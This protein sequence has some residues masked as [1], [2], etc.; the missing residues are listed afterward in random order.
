M[1]CLDSWLTCRTGSYS[2][3]NS[4]APLS[5]PRVPG[6]VQLINTFEK[7]T[8]ASKATEEARRQKRLKRKNIAKD[9]PAATPA[10]EAIPD[11][12][13]ATPDT[14]KKATKKERKIAETK[15]SEQQQHKSANEAARMAVAGLFG[16]RLGGKKSGRT[17][18]WMKG[19]GSPAVTPGKPPPSNPTSTVGTPNPE[20][21]RPA[22][23]KDKRFGLWDEDKDFSIQARDV[24][25]V[26][27]SDGR[28]SRGFVRGLSL[29]EKGD[30]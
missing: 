28:A 7:T 11:P 25:L 19:G 14:E 3:A 30:S 24:L 21:A 20:R 13:S 18:D 26:L 2:Q 16:S 12:S 5:S 8:T 4:D 27:D 1:R 9:D 29:V 10:G 22:V 6:P 17:Y 23:P 15:F